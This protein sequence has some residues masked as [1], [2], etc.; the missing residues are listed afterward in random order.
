MGRLG[1]SSFKSGPKVVILGT[2]R[3]GHSGKSDEGDVL[4]L[5]RKVDKSDESDIPA[6]PAFLPCLYC[7]VLPCLSCTWL[8]TDVHMVDHRRAHG[9]PEAGLKVV[10]KRVLGWSK[11]ES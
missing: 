4:A 11:G 9:G 6:L 7:P 10:Q 5:L 1:L 2:S 8:T 3:S